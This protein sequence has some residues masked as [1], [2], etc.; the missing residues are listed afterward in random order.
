MKPRSDE[1][2]MRA[3]HPSFG[4]DG[5]TPI[6]PDADERRDQRIG[7]WIV[8][9]AYGGA[10]ALCLVIFA[11]IALAL[12]GADAR[13]QG[14]GPQNPNCIVPTASSAGD[15]SNIVTSTACPPDRPIKRMVQQLVTNCYALT[16]SPRL[17]C[18]DDGVC[19]YAFDRCPKVC[20]TP[21]GARCFTQQEMDEAK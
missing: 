8:V 13:A 16:C 14:C 7:N 1:N 9:L 11:I 2:W 3:G 12:F 19:Y 21:I 18:P 6:D 4:W 5:R 15:N 17:V 20:S 10:V